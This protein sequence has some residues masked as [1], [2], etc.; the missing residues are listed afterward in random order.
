M[1]RLGLAT[2]GRTLRWG[3]GVAGWR[4]AGLG[5]MVRRSALTGL[6]IGALIAGL[7]A[8]SVALQGVAD[9]GVVSDEVE[10]SVVV[11]VSPT[12]YGWRLGFRPGDQI[13][14]IV[15]ADES[16][17]W[18]LVARTPSGRIETLRPAPFD[19]A[20][21]ASLPL[22]I[23]AVALAGLALLFLSTRRRWV[24]PT[25]SLALLAAGVPLVLEGNT[26]MSTAVLAGAAIVPVVHLGRRVPIGLAVRVAIVAGFLGFLALWASAR[27]TGAANA[28]ELETVRSAVAFWGALALF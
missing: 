2:S 21:R 4:I 12:G 20:L 13:V 19:A 27:L 5:Y 9:P 26:D 23:G 28:G 7:S 8:T 25:A 11:A 18:Q 10:G 14:S 6:A 15:A 22:G 24:V 3:Q 16:G 1:A 17:G